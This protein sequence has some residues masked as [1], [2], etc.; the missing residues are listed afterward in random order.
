M[1]V[2]H[3]RPDSSEARG[4]R[5]E[6]FSGELVPD[7]VLEFVPCPSVCQVL[8][9]QFDLTSYRLRLVCADQCEPVVLD[10]T[11]HIAALA[12]PGSR[13]V[14]PASQFSQ[15]CAP[16]EMQI[17]YSS[18][19]NPSLFLDFT[20]LV[21]VSNTPRYGPQ[22]GGAY[23]DR[24]NR[25]RPTPKGLGPW[26]DISWWVVPRHTELKIQTLGGLL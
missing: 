8:A 24:S 16:I 6:Q 1:P 5:L 10:C 23:V 19:V 9:D 22:H 26:F 3:R 11:G 15:W 17:L 25:P 4:V 13:D 21:T 20:V 14:S 12:L 18:A 7:D 2:N